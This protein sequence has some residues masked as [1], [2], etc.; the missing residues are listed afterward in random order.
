MSE[1]YSDGYIVS[2]GVLLTRIIEILKQKVSEGVDVRIIYDDMGSHRTLK[3]KTKK[4]IIKAGI[5][6]QSFNRL[7]PIFNIALNLRD[8]RKIVIIDGKVSYTGGVNLADE[9]VNI[10]ERFGYWMDSAVAVTGEAVNSFLAMFCSMWRF[11]TEQDI[12]MMHACNSLVI[13]EQLLEVDVECPSVR[14]SN[15]TALSGELTVV[16]IVHACSAGLVQTDTGI[17]RELEVLKEC[18][19]SEC[20]GCQGITFAVACVKRQSLERIGVLH[21]RT[22]IILVGIS[23]CAES[24]T[25]VADYISVIVIHDV[26]VAVTHV[27][28]IDRSDVRGECENVSCA[29]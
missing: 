20:L 26:S 12:D 25:I 18:D 28:R 7:V 3:R 24:V 23:S 10:V 14:F 13:I 29:A 6:L 17:D 5:K 15:Y 8:H 22:Y 21:E 1:N 9:Y 19:I 4:Q 16:R 27:K 11:T 2:N